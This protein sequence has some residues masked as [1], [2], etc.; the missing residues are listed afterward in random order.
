[1]NCSHY[2]NEDHSSFSWFVFDDEGKTLV[3]DFKSKV[4][5]INWIERKRLRSKGDHK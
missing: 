3:K 4:D 2:P 5:A 1:M